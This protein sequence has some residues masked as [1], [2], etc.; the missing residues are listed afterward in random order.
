V[1]FYAAVAASGT[2]PDDLGSAPSD[3]VEVLA[4]AAVGSPAVCALRALL[5]VGPA[6]AA[7]AGAAR[8][9]LGLRS[10][11]DG[12]EASAM[13]AGWVAGP[14][15]RACLSYCVDGNLQAVLDE[16]LHVLREWRRYDNASD[17]ADHVHRAATL[18]APSQQVDL[19]D[20]DGRLVR[21]SLR[22]R[23]AARFGNAAD[24]T[25]G[26][27]RPEHVSDAFN[28]PFWPFV[29]ATTSIG[30]EGLDFHL[31][32]H[33]VV[34]WN[35]PHNPVDLE[36]REGRVHRYKGHA[37]RKNVAARHRPVGSGDP[38]TGMFAAAALTRPAGE[39]EI[40]PYWVYP[41]DAR[42]ERHLLVAPYSRE[43]SVLPHLLNS[44]AQYRLAF[45]QPRQEEFLSQVLDRLTPAQRH[46]LAGIRVDLRPPPIAATP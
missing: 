5:R 42:I 11:F 36:Q 44:T 20:A 34:H 41:G 32:S 27:V 43:A 3:L 8:I 9:A 16:Y 37:V 1:R 39:S 40:F 2:L 14:F 31:Y 26:N 18:R 24:D 28:S 15:W 30:Q 38:W 7:I 35:L 33:A 4:L 23:F 10:L 46:E 25:T 6:S 13:V 12:P 19:V 29:L 17:L 21:Q 22:S 45:G